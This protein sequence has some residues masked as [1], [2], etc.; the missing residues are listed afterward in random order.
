MKRVAIFLALCICMSAQ[1]AFGAGKK[2]TLTGTVG[3]GTGSS[4]IIVGDKEYNFG[5]DSPLARKIF[6]A[7]ENGDKCTIVAILDKDGELEK[8]I[9]AK[10]AK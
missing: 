3:G 9:S 1:I 10:K 7:C 5:T 8:V 2:V 4:Y 6:K